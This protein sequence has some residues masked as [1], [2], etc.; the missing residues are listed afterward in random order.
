[1]TVES[2]G[3]VDFAGR[4]GGVV[5]LRLFRDGRLV[6]YPLRPG[7][8]LK[9]DPQTR[10]ASV[11]FR[12]IQLPQGA[13]SVRFSA[14]AFNTDKVKSPTVRSDY[15]V[16]AASRSKQ[17]GKAYVIAIGVNNYQNPAFNL[18]FAAQDARLVSDLMSKRLTA[19]QGYRDVVTISL[20]ADGDRLR[21]ATKARIRSVL[22]VLA[23]NTAA[24]SELAGIS[25]AARLETATPDDLVII[26]FAGH[27]Y[28]SQ[29]G[30][31]HLLPQDIGPGN[32]QRVTAQIL[33]QSIGSDEL[34]TWLRDVDAGELA[35][36]IDAC[37]S[38]AS[39][40][41]DGFK[42]GPMGSRGLGQLAYDKGMRILAASQCE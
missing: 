5:D 38:A 3:R 42:P 16:P 26:T 33:S 19:V 28:A 8:P 23:G 25:N 27:G 29:R 24:R 6:G 20:V 21:D 30:V 37:H 41:G 18:R 12:N 10:R 17:K 9:L 35:L 39:V 11:V 14:Y 2:E 15:R 13:E 7:E 1:M 36:I 31:F 4:P 40:E 22:A 32:T 34:E